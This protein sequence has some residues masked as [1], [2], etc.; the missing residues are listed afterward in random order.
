M[1]KDL[2]HEHY[3]LFSF[4]VALLIIAIWTTTLVYVVISTLTIIYM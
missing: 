3:D 1:V 4:L 2:K